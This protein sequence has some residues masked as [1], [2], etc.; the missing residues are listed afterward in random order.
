VAA[1]ASL[2]LLP[3]TALA[4]ASVVSADPA[5]G[6]LL[7]AAPQAVTIRFSESVTPAGPGITVLAPGGRLV[8]GGGGQAGDQQ[9]RA[10]VRDGGQGTY[11]VRW[12]VIAADTHPSRGQFTFSVGRTSAAPAA[13]D[14]TA[15]IGAVSPQG[16]LLQ[17]LARWLH[18]VGL[19]L[20]AGITAF[21]VLVVPEP[22]PAADRR[23]DRLVGAGIAVLVLAEPLALAAQSLSLG[24]VA[25][26]LLVS[27]FG[28]VLGLRLGGALLLWAVAGAVRQA[29]RGRWA[30]LAA[31]AAIALV[32]GAAGHRVVG[33]PDAAAFV[34]SAVHEA[35]M[36]VWVGGLVAVLATRQGAAPFRRVA[37][38]SFAVLVGSGAAMALAH[39]RGPAD[40]AGTAYGSVLAV[41]VVAVGAVA[42]IA[43]LGARR[44]E[45]AAL[46]GVLALAGLLVSLPPAR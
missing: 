1:A 7:P 3:A 22:G 6:S 23:L 17:G 29:G 15:D 8:S 12:Q 24:V 37:L 42:A 14:Q 5:P 27:S 43:G 39:L 46:A 31:G 11:L 13:E 10:S 40:L 36:A 21:R 25:G 2:A 4:H 38:T 30:L 18:F 9:L 32:D 19:A 33:L 45:A 35:A 44:L 34:L 28:R 20:A 41:K 26:D 16:L